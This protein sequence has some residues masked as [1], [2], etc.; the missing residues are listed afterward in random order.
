MTS[1]TWN[2]VGDALDI[3]VGKKSFESEIK[4]SSVCHRKPTFSFC[5]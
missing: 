5:F 4:R 1:V 3:G 2:H